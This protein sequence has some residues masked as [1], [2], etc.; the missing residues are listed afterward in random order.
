MNI[1]LLGR[2][3]QVGWELQ[4]ALA[5]LGQVIACVRAQADL[6]DFAALA[7]LVRTT[8]PDIIV[9]AAAYTAVDRAQSDAA[10]AL[11]VNAEAVGVLAAE[12]RRI[13]SLLV[14]YSTDYVFDGSKTGAYVETDTPAPLNVYGETKLAG[15]RA[16]S[17]SGCRHLT[18]RTSWVYAAR[19]SNFAATMLRLAAER[20]ELKVVNDQTGAPTSAELIADVTALALHQV[21]HHSGAVPAG[22]LYHLAANGVT[23]W[24]G[25]AQMVIGEARR[26]GAKLKVAP[27]QILPISSA[28]YPAPAK[29]PHNSTLDTGKLRRDFGLTMPPWQF[30]VQR[31]LEQQFF[32]NRS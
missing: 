27:D 4:R 25:Y 1:L 11:R 32:G 21:L 7:K 10:R 31:M 2:H 18:F 22:G 12:A 16:I 15:E 30:H 17:G 26:L 19:G 3:G 14:H 20:D 6:E 13:D 24:H 8:S 5:P 29:R 9:N 23:S 28:A